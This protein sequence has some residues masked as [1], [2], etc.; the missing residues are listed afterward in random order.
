MVVEERLK[1]WI[2][3]SLRFLYFLTKFL[4]VQMKQCSGTFLSYLLFFF[5]TMWLHIF[6]YM[7]KFKNMSDIQRLKYVFGRQRLFCILHP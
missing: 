7:E 3:Y 5:L 4:V 1:S 6:F 2:Y